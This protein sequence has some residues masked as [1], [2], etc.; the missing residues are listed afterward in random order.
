MNTDVHVSFQIMFFSGYMLKRG[1]VGSYISSAFCF[2]SDIHT[3][4]HIAYTNL[5]YHQQCRRVPFSPQSLQ[6]LVCRFFDDGHF[7]WCE[8]IS[9]C[10]FDLLLYISVFVPILY[11][12]DYCSFTNSLKAG[13]LIPSESF[14][15]LKITLAIQSL[16]CLHKNVKIFVL[17]LWKI[18]LVIW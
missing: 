7:D 11:S 16:L 10:S 6:C 18:S 8:V 9:H 2:L 3:I 12:F 14:F 1:I 13:N 5:H 4:L 15:F 17:I